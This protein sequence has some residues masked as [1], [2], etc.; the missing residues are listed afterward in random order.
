MYTCVHS[1]MSVVAHGH[2]SKESD[3]ILPRPMYR[4]GYLRH[5]V[6]NSPR[7]QSTPL[8]HSKCF[9]RITITKINRIVTLRESNPSVDLEWDI[10]THR[11]N[12]YIEAQ[13][14][15]IPLLPLAEF[16]GKV[17]L[18]RYMDVQLEDTPASE[19]EDD[20][21]EVP[22]PHYEM[23]VR[24]APFPVAKVETIGISL[25]EYLAPL[26]SISKAVGYDILH[27][28]KDIFDVIETALRAL[29]IEFAA[30]TI[31]ICED[32]DLIVSWTTPEAVAAAIRSEATA[33]P[34]VQ[35]PTNGSVYAE[36]NVALQF[37]RRHGTVQRANSNKTPGQLTSIILRRDGIRLFETSRLSSDDLRSLR[38]ILNRLIGDE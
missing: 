35:S 23:M 13:D 8:M 34:I 27:S 5:P 11:V 19:E 37:N 6:S 32:G 4:I 16:E 21:S 36:G 15:P 28:G 12:L 3:W 18:L 10:L 7:E 1:H 9:R 22:V 30:G 26:A 38:T 31:G 20:E 25:W 33:G 14:G 17:E 2:S 29:N 24:I